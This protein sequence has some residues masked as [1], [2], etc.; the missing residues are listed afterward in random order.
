MQLIKKGESIDLVKKDGGGLNEVAVGLG[1]GQKP[2][3]GFFGGIKYIEVDL[4]ASCILYDSNQTLVDVVYFQKLSSNDGS[5]V[6][7]GDDLGGGGSEN[8]PNEIISVFLHQ[9]PQNVQS[10]VFVVNSYSGETFA[11]IPF[12]FCNVTDSKANEEAARYN[13]STDGVDYKGFI[14]A[15]VHRDGGVW[16]FHAIGEACHGRQQTLDD[17]EPL[18]RR[19]A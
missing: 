10:I 1:W 5:I 9:V 15:K 12:A 17:I 18:A 13:L 19:H 2:Q 8:E 3:K 4:D 6:H 14:I 7:S 11:G 16:K